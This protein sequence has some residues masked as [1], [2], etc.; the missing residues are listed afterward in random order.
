MIRSDSKATAILLLL[1]WMI[2]GCN[3]D[4]IPEEKRQKAT[5]TNMNGDDVYTDHG[6]Y[7]SNTE[8]EVG[9][10]IWIVEDANGYN[11]LCSDDDYHTCY[12]VIRPGIDA[13]DHHNRNNQFPFPLKP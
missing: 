10:V 11:C 5:I 4:S 7:V 12:D 13:D 6:R 3:F 8:F 9:D 1:I 2:L